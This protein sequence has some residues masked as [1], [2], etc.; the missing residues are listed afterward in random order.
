MFFLM[1]PDVIHE[2]YD[3]RL[4]GFNRQLFFIVDLFLQWREELPSK[5]ICLV[6][7]IGISEIE[8]MIINGIVSQRRYIFWQ[9]FN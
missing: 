4:F 6:I 8:E 7:L 5:G 2:S 9:I 3:W 1:G